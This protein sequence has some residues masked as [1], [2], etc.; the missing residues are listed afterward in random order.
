MDPLTAFLFGFGACLLIWLTAEV[1]WPRR[2]ELEATP[3]EEF[4]LD[5]KNTPCRFWLFRTARLLFPS[6]IAF[7]IDMARA[8]RKREASEKERDEDL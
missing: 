7:W 1:S 6:A 2:R 5:P 8:R 4:G 3:E